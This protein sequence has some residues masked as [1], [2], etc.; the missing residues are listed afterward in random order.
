MREGHAEARR[1]IRGLRLPQLD[2]G[3]VL[4]AVENLVEECERR[5]KV[6]IEFCSSVAQLDLAPILENH[7]V[8]HHS[9]VPDQCLPPQSEQERE[10]RGHTG[11]RPA[12]DCR[13]RIGAWVSGWTGVGDG[14]FGLEGIQERAKVFGGHAVIKSAP[15]QGTTISVELP[16][17]LESDGTSHL[18][19]L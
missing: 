19:Q 12:A 16:L 14:H 9:G 15:N 5:N 13:S 11:R 6:E 17:P 10:G 1:L 4:V 3:G 7:G 18:G 2:E 8:S